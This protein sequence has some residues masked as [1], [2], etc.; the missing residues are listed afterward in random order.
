MKMRGAMFALAAAALVAAGCRTEDAVIRDYRARLAAGDYAGAVDEPRKRAEEGGGTLLL[1]QLMTA[2]ALDLSGDA[3]SALDWYDL[4]ESAM[5]ANDSQSVFS[6]AAGSAYA[7]MLNDRYFPYDGGGQDRIF[8]CFYKG[9][10]YAS[11]GRTDS[12]RTEFN[13]ADEHQ[14]LWLVQREKDIA[15]AGERLEKDA[16]AYSK[17]KSEGTGDDS[18]GKSSIAVSNAMNDGSFGATLKEMFG[19]DIFT[20]GVLDKLKPADYQNSYIAHA[21]GVFRWLNGDGGRSHLANAKAL[22]P[23]NATVRADFADCDAGRKPEDDVWVY[24]EDGLCPWREAW[25]IDLPVLLIPYA[26]KYV[27]YAGMSLP[28]L[29]ECP[30]AASNWHANGVRLEE[31]A[32]VDALAKIEYDVYMRGAIKREITRTVVNVGVQA[33]LGIVAENTSDSKTRLA[34]Q[35]S[36]YAVAAYAF[37]SKGADTRCW[38]ALPKRVYVARLKRPADGRLDIR[39]DGLNAAQVI[40]PEK[41]CAMVFVR[42]PSASAPCAVKVVSIRERPVF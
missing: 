17:E 18:A 4:A 2:S 22:M 31:L 13:R 24:V 28:R 10:N 38:A 40:L 30:A 37:A 42:K 23:R 7:M 26:E 15:A 5:A 39:A 14:R 8:T 1:W 6:Q 20:S 34:L 41:G 12:A 21:I 25:R 32:D 16:A 36:Q 33:A 35:L 19:F 3:A 11:L 29:R 9:V 27:K